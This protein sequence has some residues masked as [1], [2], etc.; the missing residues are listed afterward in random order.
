LERLKSFSSSAESLVNL[1]ALQMI[2]AQVS[3]FKEINR[4]T[5]FC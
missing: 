4:K 1:N 5:M 2:K 3:K